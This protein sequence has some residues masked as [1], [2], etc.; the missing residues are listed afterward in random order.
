MPSRRKLAAQIPFIAAFFVLGALAP[1]ALADRGGNANG[2]NGG[3]P[4]GTSTTNSSNATTTTT[5]STTTSSSTTTSKGGGKAGKTSSG[6][7]ALALT[8][9]YIYNMPNAAAPLSCLNE[10]DIDQRTF[11]GSLSG[12]FST[13]YQLCATWNGGMYW[14]AGG[15]GLETDVT[16]VGPIS[17]LAI[18]SPAGDAHHAV[19]MGTTTSNG[20]TTYHYAACYMPPFSLSTNTGTDPLA[21]GTW[22]MT[23]SG[24]FT[25]ATWH[26][27]VQMAYPSFQQAYCP[28]SEENL[29]P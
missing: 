14:S 6:S 22:T 5:A 20:V 16:S 19:L 9:E 25:K 11:V 7:S 26:T 23:L 29:T 18:S 12:S 13:S 27:T 1:L 28:P 2:G 10:D 3:A 8:S 21:S 15:E 4:G 17:D 24:T